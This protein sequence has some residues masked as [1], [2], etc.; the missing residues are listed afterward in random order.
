VNENSFYQLN[1]HAGIDSEMTK[2]IEGL[3]FLL[4]IVS[5]AGLQIQCTSP[6]YS[7]YISQ[8]GN[9]SNPG[10]KAK[11]FK[12]LQKINS[13]KL[14]PG[15]KIYLKGKDLFQGTL[16][17]TI[18]GGSDE[19][20]LITSY[21]NENG[22]A[23]IDGGNK[24]AIILRGKY[25]QLK[26]INVKGSGRKAGNT[27]NGITLSEASDAVVENIKTEGFQKSGIELN[28]CKNVTVKNVYSA[29][30]GFCGIYITGSMDKRSKH[31]LVKDCKAENNAGDP[32][33]LDNHSGNGI[34]AGLSD[35]VT[36]DH[37]VATSNGWDMP[38]IGNGPVGIWAYE[39]NAVTIQ[40]CISYRNKTSKG[41]KD[42]GGFDLD[43][44]V[45]N[46]IIQYCL[47]YENEG[48]GY[49]LFQYAG[50]SLWHN[51][52][53]RY[54]VSIN[55]VT[56]TAGSG[57]IFV[58]NGS[59]DSVQLADCIVHNNVVYSTH[60]PAIQF[61]PMSKN[62]NFLFANN[63]FIGADSIAHG[64]SSG[65]RFVNN[66]WWTAAGRIFFRHYKNIEE[67]SAAT[68]Q[69]KL[70]GELKGKQIDPKLRGPF[71]TTLTNPYQLDSLIGYSLMPDSPV[72]N[73]LIDLT[74]FQI[75]L[76][77]HDF[78]NGP[79]SQQSNPGVQQLER[80]Q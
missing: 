65:E 11:P 44:G 30:N 8:D 71:A 10:T 18:N 36:I 48:A 76:A 47:S 29:D 63:I 7:Y 78:F 3:L 53:V 2:N 68:G 4:L 73:S 13:L 20:V 59:D 37:C 69:E 49:G 26:D 50:A 19:A 24:D 66:I 45:T 14:N 22:N 40:Y 34:L 70:N 16:S 46:S 39:S 42:G 32:T 55:D 6:T 33:N 72:K 77:P 52:M 21:E 58:W 12:T 54:C 27:T 60:A 64:P 56:T 38:R 17:L 41:G 51:N 57:G 25:F 9:D 43:G 74:T 61:E 67:W 1:S 28:S 79:V 75:P 23:V 5:T 31:I 15:D 35:S 62:R 80:N